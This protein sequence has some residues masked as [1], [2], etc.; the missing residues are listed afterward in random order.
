MTS[1]RCRARSVT[2]PTAAAV[3]AIAQ[4]IINVKSVPRF[5]FF[6]GNYIDRHASVVLLF[7]IAHGRETLVYRML[8]CDFVVYAVFQL[9]DSFCF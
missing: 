5:R 8:S 4:Q 6:H 3:E 9:L 1:S 2:D 7:L